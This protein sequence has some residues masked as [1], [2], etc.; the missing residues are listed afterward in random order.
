[1]LE[2]VVEIL[3]ALCLVA[4]GLLCFA[5]GLGIVRFQ[6]VFLRMHAATKAG[7]LGLMFIVLALCLVAPGL[8]T[9]IKA[10]LVSVFMIITAP[11]GSHLIGRAA[12]RTAAPFWSGTGVDEDCEVF[13]V[14][15]ATARMRAEKD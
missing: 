9:A 13:R 7:T 8:E 10:G 12:F 15:A 3:A 1:M 5:A 2:L 14:G 4:G 6:D 11:V